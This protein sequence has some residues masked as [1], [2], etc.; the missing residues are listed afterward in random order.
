[1]KD[2]AGLVAAMEELC[3]SFENPETVG[4]HEFTVKYGETLRVARGNSS[5]E[6][7]C[8]SS[9]GLLARSRTKVF[10]DKL[11]KR[12]CQPMAE[13]AHHS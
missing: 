10:T 6:T 5:F 8:G 12:P 11:R 7:V 2:P 13:V 4:E 3:K 1:M 9:D